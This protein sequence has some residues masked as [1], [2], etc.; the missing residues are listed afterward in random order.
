MAIKKLCSVYG[1]VELNNVAGVRTGEIVSQYDM[2]TGVEE[3][4]NGML[5]AVDHAKETVGKPADQDA[6]VYLHASVE[7]EYE[8]RGRKHFIQKRGSFLPRAYKLGMGDTFETNAVNY[9]KASVTELANAITETAGFGIP[10]ASGYIKF[11]DA[12]LG[13]EV[14]ALKAV[15]MVTLP[16]GEMG[17]KFRVI[18]AVA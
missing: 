18:K 17:I 2:A 12:L 4:E 11:V 13:T 7:K 14:V 8:G 16:N 6:V 9:D 5:V 3:L 15:K 10:D 1:V